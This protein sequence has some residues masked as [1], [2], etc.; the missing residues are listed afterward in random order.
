M[1]KLLFYTLFA[2][3]L[4]AIAFTQIPEDTGQ[5]TTYAFLAETGP[6]LRNPYNP[7]NYAPFRFVPLQFRDRPLLHSLL[8]G[9]DSFS[10]YQ[11]T[12]QPGQAFF[13]GEVWEHQPTSGKPYRWEKKTLSPAAQT[14]IAL[15]FLI[16]GHDKINSVRW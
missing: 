1:K 11:A 14:A 5:G 4:P 8:F 6:G 16:I 3:I 13:R 2:L 7:Q 15:P 9:L 12:L 10:G